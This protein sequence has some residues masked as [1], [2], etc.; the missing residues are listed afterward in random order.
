MDRWIHMSTSTNT[1]QPIF[2]CMY[3]G[4]VLHFSHTQFYLFK[5]L[6]WKIALFGICVS[7]M[8]FA[9]KLKLHHACMQNI[10]VM[11]LALRIL[12]TFSFKRFRI[13]YVQKFHLSSP[14]THTHT[15]LPL[16]RMCQKV[17]FQWPTIACSNLTI[18]RYDFQVPKKHVK[19]KILKCWSTHVC[20]LSTFVLNLI[21]LQW[22]VSFVWF[23]KH[24]LCQIHLFYISVI[25]IHLCATWNEYFM[26]YYY[27]ILN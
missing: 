3:C 9:F 4:S 27:Q 21:L 20:M 14:L 23:P 2:L 22:S 12:F 10:A 11:Y 19:W 17:C 18:C 24:F 8:R 5:I 13:K 25:L 15:A 6:I 7:S 16:R 1:I 26:K